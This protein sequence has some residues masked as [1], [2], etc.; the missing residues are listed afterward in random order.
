MAPSAKASLKEMSLQSWRDTF[1]LAVHD[2]NFKNGAFKGQIDKFTKEVDACDILIRSPLLSE[3]EKAVV[4]ELRKIL[5]NV[6][7]TDSFDIVSMIGQMEIME[8][9]RK[10][11]END[12]RKQGQYVPPPMLAQTIGDN[13]EVLSS[14]EIADDGTTIET[15]GGQ[16]GVAP[17]SHAEF[18]GKKQ[19]GN[20][21]KKQ[22]IGKKPTAEAQTSGKDAG[23]SVNGPGES[24]PHIQAQ[25]RC[26]NCDH[27]RERLCKERQ[28]NC[29]PKCSRR[30]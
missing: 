1:F 27:C 24:D 3:K 10:V 19:G 17:K 5:L 23:D 16:W 12:R 30:D 11:F 26:A 15:K 6:I 8:K 29:D 22:D 14:F 25:I 28:C 2:W 13:N 7:A 4:S 18:H 21:K 20:T 9:I